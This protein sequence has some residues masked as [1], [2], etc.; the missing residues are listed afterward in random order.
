MVG[1]R[2]TLLLCFRLNQKNTVSNQLQKKNQKKNLTKDW[3]KKKLRL[4]KKFHICSEFPENF[5]SESWSNLLDYPKGSFS[6][7]MEQFLWPFQ[8]YFFHDLL[9]FS[10]IE[11]RVWRPTTCL[12]MVQNC[13]MFGGFWMIL[14]PCDARN[15][16]CLA[17]FGYFSQNMG[18]IPGRSWFCNFCMFRYICFQHF[19]K[20]LKTCWFSGKS[21]EDHDLVGN[22]PSSQENFKL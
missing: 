5:P 4:G 15:T 8:A 21:Y 20:Y 7:V 18:L 9:D 13:S 19:W 11:A 16:I 14:L 3:C 6:Q 22:L 1:T 10:S 12:K 2:S 17:L